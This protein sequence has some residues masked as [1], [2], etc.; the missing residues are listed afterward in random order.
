MES[1]EKFQWRMLMFGAVA[2]VINGERYVYMDSP[3]AC[4]QTFPAG[5]REV[6]IVKPRGS[7]GVSNPPT[8]CSVFFES[9]HSSSNY[10][11]EIVIEASNVRDCGM[12]L[13][14][15]DGQNTA[16]S[17]I[18]TIGC[19]STATTGHEYSKDRSISLLLT[20]TQ[21]Q[22]YFGSDFQLRIQLYYDQTAADEYI[23]TYKFPVGAIVGV[24][25]GVLVIIV[26]AIL[27]GWCYKTGRLPGFSPYD[28]P[29]N[30]TKASS[31]ILTNPV[32]EPD[33]TSSVGGFVSWHGQAPKTVVPD[34]RSNF[35][36]DDSSIFQSLTSLNAGSVTPRRETK[37]VAIPRAPAI[38][39]RELNKG[40]QNGTSARDRVPHDASKSAFDREDPKQLSNSPTA[41][42]R[43]SLMRNAGA[44]NM[45]N[46]NP[47]DQYHTI[48]DLERDA[49]LYVSSS[50]R[51]TG[52]GTFGSDNENDKKRD[53][54]GVFVN[55]D[56]EGYMYDY[57]QVKK[58]SGDDEVVKREKTQDF[59]TELQD[60]IKRASLKRE[61]SGNVTSESEGL[62]GVQETTN[63]SSDFSSTGV[64][65][66]T[67]G[68]MTGPDAQSSPKPKKKKRKNSKGKT[69]KQKKEKTSGSPAETSDSVPPEIFAPIFSGDDE[70]SEAPNQYQPGYQGNYPPA[71]PFDPR[72]PMGPYQPGMYGPPGYPPGI[73]FQQAG[74][75][76]WYVEANP[77]GQH[78]MAFAMTT[79]SQSDD[80]HHGGPNYTSTPYHTKG[81][82]S[83]PNDMSVVPSGTILDDPRLPDPGTSLVRY[84][85][86]P[87]SG[88]KSS[89]V[90][91]TDARRDPTDPPPDSATQITRKTITR[92]T[93]RATQDELPDAPNPGLQDMSWRAAQGIQES[94]GMEPDFMSPTKGAYQHSAIQ[95]ATETP[96][97][98][99]AGFYMGSQRGSRTTPVQPRFLPASATPIIHEAPKG[100]TAI[101]DRITLL[102]KSEA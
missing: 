14:I 28:Y 53:S 79:H 56:K 55:P 91:W 100:N 62:A 33:G 73:P 83:G 65:N 44:F 1:V 99:N 15:F 96:D 66:K 16:G 11:F 22:Y 27:L 69:K 93:T 24:V 89:Q 102:P 75:A 63:E 7:V 84:D 48:N 39:G 3:T 38:G 68:E 31:E 46:E 41:R 98:S 10:K 72:Y 74:Q 35:G 37:P 45:E 59:A 29:N 12:M 51:M 40:V 97:R 13:R 88:I 30:N 90:V 43:T 94:R 34:T 20:R 18:R 58:L 6:F 49:D 17:D 64:L 86:D 101:K 8:Q 92:I 25:L 61:L 85:E 5:E 32:V 2:A 77:N 42:K 21:N 50:R 26:A 76:Q 67:D 54:E 4:G 60:A 19:G 57:E 70:P 52:K 80:G 71:A 87:L 47:K 95:Y 81:Q 82:R 23:G 9:S 36:V 78:K